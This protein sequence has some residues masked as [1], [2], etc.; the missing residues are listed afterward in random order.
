MPKVGWNEAE[1]SVDDGSYK[2]ATLPFQ[3]LP[4]QETNFEIP[5]VSKLRQGELVAVL[6]WK[7]GAINDK[8]IDLKLHTQFVAAED[9]L[10]NVDIYSRNCNGLHI[11]MDS[12]LGQEKSSHSQAIRFS[13]LGP[14]NYLVYASLNSAGNQTANATESFKETEAQLKIYSSDSDEAVYSVSLPLVDH[15]LLKKGE[16]YWTALC[17]HGNDAASVDTTFSSLDPKAILSAKPDVRE[18]CKAQKSVTKAPPVVHVPRPYDISLQRMS[19]TEALIKWEENSGDQKIQGFR[20]FIEKKDSTAP[21]LQ[22]VTGDKR[23]Y[24][25]TTPKELMDQT[26]ILTIQA[27]NTDGRIS[28]LSDPYQFK[29]DSNWVP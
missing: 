24:T 16:V 12:F 1:V 9:A 26:Y 5:L 23:F 28:L 15:D 2:T 13:K 8:S 29:L 11:S 6:Q 14:F 3:A 18:A 20:I 4:G 27:I 25:L 21:S 10:C 22:L 7:S 19:P 17:I